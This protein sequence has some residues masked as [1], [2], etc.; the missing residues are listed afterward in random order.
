MTSWQLRPRRPHAQVLPNG[1]RRS[2]RLPL[3]EKL[4][5]GERWQEAVVRGVV[6][7]LGPVLPA[8]P[9]VR[10][11]RHGVQTQGAGMLRRI[12]AAVSLSWC[13]QPSA[14]SKPCSSPCLALTSPCSNSTTNHTPQV[15]V[16]EAS[17]EES[18][19]TKESQ[20]YPGLQSKVG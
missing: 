5:P 18:V 7:E 14:D 13:S 17:M 19:E 8:N 2:R 3:S 6:E 1:N 15:E 12:N 20:S 4:L 16:D 10:T 11:G 9:E